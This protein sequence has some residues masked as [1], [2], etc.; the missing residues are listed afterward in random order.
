MIG[1]MISGIQASGPAMMN[2]TAMKIS[3]NS[4]SV[5]GHHGAGGEEFAHRIE[6]AH[7]VGEDADRGRPLRHLHRQHVL[8]DVRGQHDVELLAGHVDD[9]AADHAQDE[10]EDD[11]NDQADRQRDQRGNRAV[12]HHAVVDVHDEERAASASMLTISAAIATWL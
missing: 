6:V 2:R 8:E 4:R 1:S 7:L 12:G 9:A 5:I 10:V 3:A 11:R